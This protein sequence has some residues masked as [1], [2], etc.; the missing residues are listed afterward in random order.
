MSE[1]Q[2]PD[3]LLTKQSLSWIWAKIKSALSGKVDKVNG[4][5]LSTNDYTTAEKEKLAGITVMTGATAIAN[6]TSGLVPAPTSAERGKFLSG[7]A[8]WEEAFQGSN[9]AIIENTNIATH[10]ISKGYYIL[11]NGTLYQATSDISIG[12]TL[13]SSNLTLVSSGGLNSLNDS[14]ALMVPQSAI[15]NNLT[16]TDSGFVLDARQGKSL[17]DSVSSKIETSAI[18]NNLTTTD[19]GYV[20]D[21]RQG[22][23]LSDG[24]AN[25]IETSAIKN[26]LTTTDSGYVLD[27]RAGKSLKDSVDAK[28][29]T[30]AI[31]NNLTTTSSGYVLDARQGKTL[32]DK[33]FTEIPSNTDLNTITA[34]GLY[35]CANSTV[36]ST[37]SNC[38]M[39]GGGFALF[40]V[41]K[42][43]SYY[44]QIIF[45]GS[46]T[47]SRTKTSSG[48]GT[49]YKYTG[50]A[51]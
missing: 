10:A 3:R 45:S 26:N 46:A 32:A 34:V 14:I 20:L 27:A 6:G 1:V 15:K 50:T 11:W 37:L 47:Y 33:W 41:P 23:A 17:S 39:S 21:A 38:P 49:W 44:S 28:V 42:S 36:C 29:N 30:S 19:S 43:T 25:K 48:W 16:T 51:V 18:K 24:L 5:G 35:G 2:N 8:T 4:K 12:D 31:K 7:S 13:S 9:I 22:K 40:L